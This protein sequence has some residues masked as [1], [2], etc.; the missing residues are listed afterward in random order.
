MRRLVQAAWKLSRGPIARGSVQSIVIRV[1]GLAIS[2]VQGILAARLLGARGYGIA[3]F[4]LS[5]VQIGSTLA[6]FGF[7]RLAVR[8]VA[9]YGTDGSGNRLAAFIGAS[10]PAVIVLSATI[11][12]MLVLAAVG[13][14][15][16]EAYRTSLLVCGLAVL[17]MAM[18]QLQRGIAQGLGRVASAQLPGEVLRPA[19]LA[20]FLAAIAATQQSLVPQGYVGAFAA[21]AL[22]ALVL[23]LPW[24]F[25]GTRI[26]ATAR[27]DPAEGRRL[28]L[29]ALPFFGIAL[30]AILLGE[31]NT[32]LLGWLATPHEAGLFQPVA[33]FVPLM[34]L[35]VQAASMRFA[36]RISELWA[37]GDQH[38]IR[39]LSRIFTYTTL[40]LT[41]LVSLA[42]GLGGPWLMAAFGPEFALSASLLWIAG[43]AQVISAACGPAGT[44]L[45]M[46]GRTR[47]A[48]AAQLAGLATNLVI[49]IWLIGDYGAMGAAIAMA[50]G[51]VAWSIAMLVSVRSASASRR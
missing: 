25:R 27:S 34:A 19:L 4:V 49:G 20:C 40:V 24:T 46:G 37:R 48:I 23:S 35:P 32:L 18:L 22:V 21:A 16:P 14:L 2:F 45:T 36:P 9:R 29:E 12:G 33:R 8:E 5:L 50:G 41:I 43:A 47:A 13:G 30:L 3:A 1:A 6:V 42:I 44:L 38:E 26:R 17:P 39:R 51:T 7:G 28:R 31:I 15:V 11:G 10:L